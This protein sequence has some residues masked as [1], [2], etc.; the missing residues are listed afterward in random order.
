M[1]QKPFLALR[2]LLQ[3]SE[4]GLDKPLA[5]LSLRKLENKN[6]QLIHNLPAAPCACERLAVNIVDKEKGLIDY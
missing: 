3:Q 2:E 4:I 1:C 6:P 5:H